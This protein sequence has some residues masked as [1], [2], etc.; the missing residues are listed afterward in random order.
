[1]G[2]YAG[3]AVYT[4]RTLKLYDIVVLGISNNWIWKCPTPRL[5]NFYNRNISSNHLDVGVGTGYFL[6]HC[7]F[8]TPT[9]RVE[10][11][12]L[13]ADSLASTAQRIAHHKPV[14]HRAN[15]LEPLKIKTQPFDS[16]GVNYLFHCLPGTMAGKAI[17]FDHLNPYLSPKGVIFG[18]TLLQGGVPRTP[19]ARKLMAFYNRKGIFSNTSDTLEALKHALD[20]RFHQWEVQAIGCAALFWA[21]TPK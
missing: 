17:A 3:Q 11:L 15:I 5:L 7:S 2:A 10:L 14:T 18:S 8:P 1:M 12:D 20:Q 13:N 6:D 16:I 4:K 9:P 21:K 19:G